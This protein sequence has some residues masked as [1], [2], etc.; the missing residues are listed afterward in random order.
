MNILSRVSLT[1]T[2]VWIGESVYWMFTS[3]DYTRFLHSQDYCNHSTCDVT[4]WVF[5]F[6]FWPHCCSLGTSELKW[7]QFPFPYSLVSFRHGPRTENTDPPYCCASQTTHKTSHVITI[8]PVHWL[9]DCC[10]ATSYKH[11]SY[12]CVTLSEVFIAPMP[13]YTRYNT[14]TCPTVAGQRDVERTTKTDSG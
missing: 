2:R 5:W 11:S 8:S 7:S 14:V 13:S 4:H 10:L 3:R 6:F 1:K 12:C 9:A